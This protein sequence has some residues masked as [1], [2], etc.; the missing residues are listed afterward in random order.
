M[1]CNLPSR[2]EPGYAQV[3]KRDDLDANVMLGWREKDLENSRFRT[4]RRAQ[5]ITNH[6][7]KLGKS[8]VAERGRTRD[9][10]LLFDSCLPCLTTTVTVLVEVQVLIGCTPYSV[11]LFGSTWTG[12]T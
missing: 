5:Q 6:K 12:W 1:V 11:V 3:K 4:I 8:A 10:S 9:F 7:A 2:S